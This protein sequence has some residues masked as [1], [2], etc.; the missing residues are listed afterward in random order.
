MEPKDIDFA[1]IPQKAINVVTRPAEF[2]Q[3]MQKTGGFVEPLLFAVIMGLVSGVIQAILGIFGLGQPGGM[4]YG[5]SSIILMPV[6]VAIGSFIGAAVMFVIWKLTGSR[7]NY[8]TAYRCVAY[9]MALSPITTILGVIPYAGAVIAAAI[10]LFYVVMASVH[11]HRIDALKAWLVFGIITAIMLLLSVYAQYKARSLVSD[12]AKWQKMGEEM[13]K[14]VERAGREISPA[15]E[16]M[17]RQ[18]QMMAEEARRQYEEAQR[19]AQEER[20]EDDDD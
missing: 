19:R 17:S 11:V 15:S 2:F 13:R 7:E 3:S 10:G 5:F 18:A 16:E 12:G 8:E 6:A 1:A 9:T 14:E 4:S 20:E